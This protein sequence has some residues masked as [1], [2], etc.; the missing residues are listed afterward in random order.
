MFSDE[1]TF[2]ASGTVNQHNTRTWG[3][4]TP[5]VVLEESKHSLKVNVRRGLLH[6]RIIGPYFFSEVT[7]RSDN[8]LDLLEIFAFPQIEDLQPNNVFQQYKAS[9]H[10]S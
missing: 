3:L 4:E 7:V 6:D 8:Y 10:W 9:P 5:R 1:A 2:H